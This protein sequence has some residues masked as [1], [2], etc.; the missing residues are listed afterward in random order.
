[1]AQG[2]FSSPRPH[3]EEERE[4]EQAFRQ[5][6]GQAPPQQ[7]ADVSSDYTMPLPKTPPVN[8]PAEDFFDII[9]EDS[10]FS[11][12]EP[13]VY[14]EAEPDFLDKL[15]DFFSKNKQ[16][17]LV[18]LCSAA[19]FLILAVVGVLLFSGRDA[20]DGMILD[21][22]Y[23]GTVNVGGMTEEEAAKALKPV[24][25]LYDQ[26]DMVVTLGTTELRLTP[27]DTGVKLDIDALVEEAY[28]HGRGGSKAELE[29]AMETAKTQD[30]IIGL[31]PYLNLDEPYILDT[32]SKCAQDAGSTLTQTTYGLEGRQPELSADKFDEEAP[33]QTLVITMGT[34]G[35]GFDVSAV[36]NMVLD[37][38][39]MTNFQV[40]VESV[41]STA[42]PEPIDLLAIL[43]EFYIAPVDASVD[44]QTFEPV[45]GSYGYSFN[46][47]SAQKLV[48]AAQY[49]E[50]IR[51][52]MEYIAPEI[53]DE[54]ILFRDIIGE[55]RTSHSG[56]QNRTTNLRLACE[57][58]NG[59]VLK[60][61]ETLSFNETLGQRTAAKGYKNAPSYANGDVVDSIGGGI[62]QVSSTLYYATLIADL[63]I[64]T[65]S[66]HSY[67]SAYIDYG[68]DATVSWGGPDFKFR[69][70]TNYPIKIEAY[71]QNGYVY[72]R[73]W[74]TAERNYYV[75]M[76]Y[77]ITKVLEPEIE[78]QDFAHDN[79]EGYKDGDVIKEGTTGY[80]VK[81]YKLKYSTE[82]GKLLS[83]DFAANSNYKVVNKLVARVAPAPTEPPTEAPTTPPTEAPAPS[84]EPIAPPTEPPVP[85]TDPVI[86]PTEAPSAPVTDTTLPAQEFE[87]PVEPDMTPMG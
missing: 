31:L 29:A 53:L 33:G 79:A 14:P 21:N 35:I 52:P 62:C 17:I 26:S 7:K 56:G 41:D 19:L 4:I 59:K 20:N 44:M 2:K 55:G 86:A 77:E 78:Y 47:E 50:V 42:E 67:P 87:V 83:R 63:D 9:P 24:A 30:H 16:M 32:L 22:V 3:R 60:P 15:M 85:A 25:T 70:S 57:A 13:V 45:P 76:E 61:G 23:I 18:G 49:G 71:E 65:R 54:A 46:V 66:N 58:L 11:Y 64:V 34:P 27:K 12:E 80:Q 48:D 1:M 37:A 75:Q 84:T 73:I 39:S 36:Y 10:D 81:T 6:T 72:I 69:N 68:M 82:S 74:G 28:S 8:V 5:I 43:D 40:S 38:Y 51:I